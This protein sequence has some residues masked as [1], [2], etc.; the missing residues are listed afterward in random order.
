MVK[1]TLSSLSTL[2]QP[3]TVHNVDET[4]FLKINLKINL[5]IGNQGHG[6]IRVM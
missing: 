2:P 1:M 4:I 6:Q 3:D 5:K